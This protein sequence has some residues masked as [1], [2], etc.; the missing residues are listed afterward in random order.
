MGNF[1]TRQLISKESS[2]ITGSLIV[3][4]GITG[5]F[6]GSASYA[7]SSSYSFNSGTASYTDIVTVPTSS[8]ANTATTSSI[9]LTASFASGPQYAPTPSI[10]LISPTIYFGTPTSNI[11]PTAIQYGGIHFSPVTITKNCTAVTMSCVMANQLGAPATVRYAIYSNSTSSFLPEFLLGQCSSSI[12]NTATAIINNANFSSPIS[13]SAN[14]I[15][16]VAFAPFNGIRF[17]GDVFTYNFQTYNPLLQQRYLLQPLP[18][19]TSLTYPFLGNNVIRSGSAFGLT[20][21]ATA[22]QNSNTY[23]LIQ[24]GSVSVPAVPGYVAPFIRVTY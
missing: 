2:V 5:S 16:W 21:P 20:F 1:K 8:F 3:L 11:N 4:S 13:L 24:S 7:D 18:V 10:G 12:I 22:S 17:L 19:V 15:Y 23:T 14:T 6:F 9:A